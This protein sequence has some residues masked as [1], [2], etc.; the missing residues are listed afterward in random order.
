[1][2]LADPT[3]TALVP[4]S[5]GD[6]FVRDTVSA[7]CARSDA[8]ARV[9][10]GTTLSL[11]RDVLEVDGS[12]LE[13]HPRDLSAGQQLALAIAVA[14]AAHPAQLLIDEPTR[15]LDEQARDNLAHL[16][17]QVSTRVQIT[18]ASHDAQFVRSL[19]AIAQVSA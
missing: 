11:L 13:R 2:A 16:L 19:N 10:P 6:F 5:L 18:A 15:G 7:E 4:E 8:T 17:A 1:M 9:A 12:T 14:L 3:G